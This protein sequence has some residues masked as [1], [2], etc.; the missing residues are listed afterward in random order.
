MS[1]EQISICIMTLGPIAVIGFLLSIPSLYWLLRIKRTFRHDLIL[2]LVITDILKCLAYMALPIAAWAG[3]GVGSH[4]KYC[5]VSGFLMAATVEATDFVIVLIA[6]QTALLVF[7]QYR[8]PGF[9][10]L[11]QH[12]YILYVAWIVI[13]CAMAS[14]AFVN[15]KDAYVSMG[16]FCYL[17]IR[18][19]WYR[20]T[21][22]FIPRSLV[23]LSI[24]GIYSAIYIHTMRSLKEIRE[25]ENS[26]STHQLYLE[27][28]ERLNSTA[29]SMSP[30][31]ED[32]FN[33]TQEQ[34]R[35]FNDNNNPDITLTEKEHSKV[36]SSLIGSRIR[37]MAVPVEQEHEPG[38]EFSTLISSTA[39]STGKSQRPISAANRGMS[40]MEQKRTEIQRQLR[41]LFVYPVVY[42][43]MWIYPMVCQVLAWSPLYTAGYLP[44]GFRF[45][46]GIFLAAQ[47]GVEC[48][49]F[50][51]REKPWQKEKKPLPQ[52][53]R[54]ISNVLSCGGVRRKSDIDSAEREMV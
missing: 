43:A 9:G 33:F 26:S 18:P 44:F 6:V 31:N 52:W 35:H 10:G 39:S 29:S 15:N 13:P 11:F 16:P 50:L 21:M 30:K 25:A 3:M 32:M 40:T 24:L 41:L 27:E 2:L 54:S 46:W 45:V 4:S 23:F 36:Q 37:A 34:R 1:P 17:P 49:V 22:A 28:T 14:I 48:I 47:P 53:M 42:L 20:L 19:V 51:L 7:R 5:Q 38:S 8:D 12:R